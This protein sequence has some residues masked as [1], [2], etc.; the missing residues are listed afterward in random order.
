MVFNNGFTLYLIIA[1]L[2]FRKLCVQPIDIQHEKNGVLNCAGNLHYIK[3]VYFTNIRSIIEMHSPK[4]IKSSKRY[5]SILVVALSGDTEL[6]PGPKAP[7]SPCGTCDKAANWKQQA[8]CCDTCNIWYHTN[9]Q[10]MSFNVYQYMDS[11]N[12]S[13]NCIQCGMPNFSSS[14]Y[15]LSSLE[16]SNSF[17]P[18]T[19]KSV[20]SPGLPKATSSPKKR[21][22]CKKNNKKDIPLK[23][24]NI[25]FQSIKNKRP[26]IDE[27]L[28]SVKP[29]IIICTE[30]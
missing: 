26:E 13:W 6:N 10:G 15:D 25:N 14:I 29:D 22:M 12:L 24:L 9:C 3:S 30:T 4:Y 11:S 16:T 5:L 1:I 27:I 8:L 20:S 17:S 21:H 7:K 28:T 19:E 2:V 18:L 23:V